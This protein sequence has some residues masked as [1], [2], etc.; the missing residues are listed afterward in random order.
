VAPENAANRNA[1]L[2]AIRT[3]QRDA[4]VRWAVRPELKVVAGVFDVR[5]PYFNLDERQVFTLLG[6]VEHR[7]IEASLSGKLTPRLD[8]VA[9]GVFMR[10]RVTGEGVALGRVGPRPV[11]QPSRTL[12]LNLDW[13]PARLE[14]LSFD[15]GVTHL[16][17]RPATRSNSV[18]L[19]ARTLVDFGARY[20][21]EVADRDASLRLRVTNLFNIHGWDLRGAG[22]YDLFPGRVGS[23]ALAMDF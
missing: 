10:P 1:A 5:K 2:P 3:R 20:R 7:G 19:P 12:Q 22:A 4:G 23:V 18:Y 21:F 8:I 17:R 9:G 13:R 11:G 6:D 16:S 15:V 14:G